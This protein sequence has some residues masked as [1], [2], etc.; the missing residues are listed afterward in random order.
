MREDE[1]RQNKRKTTKTEV[2]KK[3]E[4]RRICYSGIRRKMQEC[5]DVQNL[6]VSSAYKASTALE[7]LL[8]A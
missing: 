5:Q 2:M 1:A 3:K 8:Q 7:S 6:S 4:N